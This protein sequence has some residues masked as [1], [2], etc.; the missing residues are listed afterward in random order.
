MQVFA[1]SAENWRRSQS[2]IG[3]LLSLTQNVLLQELSHLQKE[4]VMLRFIGNRRALP[5]SL[6]ALIARY[7][8][9]IYLESHLLG[10]VM[11]ISNQQEPKYYEAREFFLQ[12]LDLA[13][14]ETDRGT[15]QLL[16][17]VC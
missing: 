8:A 12:A 16:S 11:H 17:Q 9:I 14:R 2:E 10:L 7:A 15:G 3:F 4:G 5:D 1:F 6:Q 13:L